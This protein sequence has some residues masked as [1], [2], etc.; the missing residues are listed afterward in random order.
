[1]YKKPTCDVS[2][3]GSKRHNCVTFF[4]LVEKY[5]HFSYPKGD[6]VGTGSEISKFG[7]EHEKCGITKCNQCVIHIRPIFNLSKTHL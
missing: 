4:W 5:I 2:Q 7:E 6:G 1:M 3:K